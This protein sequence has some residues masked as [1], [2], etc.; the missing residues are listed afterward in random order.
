MNF[1][2]IT[3][4]LITILFISSSCKKTQE[5]PAIEYPFTL[6]NATVEKKSEIQI[7]TNKQEIKDQAK[8]NKFVE[9][10]QLFNLH[11]Q[12]NRF[13]S[14]TVLSP[15][16]VF[17]NYPDNLYTYENKDGKF[18]FYSTFLFELGDGAPVSAA[19]LKYK[20]PQINTAQGLMGKEI[21]VAKGT[22]KNLD[23]SCIA[24]KLSK[25]KL[26][27]NGRLVSSIEEEGVVYNEFNEEF[28]NSLGDRDTLAVQRFVISLK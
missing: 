4:P 25:N 7:Y 28:I 1:K 13:G 19:L 18:F 14:L 6:E 20:E 9:A 3:L 24:Y 21:R 27:S 15:D 16:S 2:L 23:F 11:L 5:E 22:I 8:A 26:D 17:F 10:S 12:E